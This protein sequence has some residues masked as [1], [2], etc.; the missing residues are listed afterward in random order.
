MG[1]ILHVPLCHYPSKH[2]VERMSFFTAWKNIRRSVEML[3]LSF[4]VQ[5]VFCKVFLRSHSPTWGENLGVV[6]AAEPRQEC[7]L[8]CWRREEEGGR[9]MSWYHFAATG[10]VLSFF[11]GMTFNHIREQIETFKSN[12]NSWKKC[13]TGEVQFSRGRA[14]LLAYLFNYLLLI[15]QLLI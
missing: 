7:T 13:N 11:I 15:I 9:E 2:N 8:P 14:R 1:N 4:R 12:E 5:D 3:V 6:M 10:A